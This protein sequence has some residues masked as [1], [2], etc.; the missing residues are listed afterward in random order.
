[1]TFGSLGITVRCLRP[2]WSIR[3]PLA[4]A[5]TTPVVL[6]GAEAALLA[7]VHPQPLDV[8]SHQA[9]DQLEIVAAVRGRG[10]E[11]RLEEL[12]ETE[13]RWAAGELVLDELRR[14]LGPFLREHEIEERV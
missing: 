14:R 3:L 12:V 13:Q 10:E 5:G 9:L 1:M 6:L 7:A 8:L 11:L 4:A 2:A